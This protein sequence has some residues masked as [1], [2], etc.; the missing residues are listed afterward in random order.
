M[1]AKFYN[2]FDPT[3]TKRKA[4][5]SKRGNVKFLTARQLAH[6]QARKAAQ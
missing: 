2:K 1:K 3:S 4:H 6:L 5:K